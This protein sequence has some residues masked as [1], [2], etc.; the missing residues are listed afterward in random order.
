[1]KLDKNKDL[2]QLIELEQTTPITIRE[3]CYHDGCPTDWT[4]RAITPRDIARQSIPYYCNECAHSTN[5]QLKQGER[6]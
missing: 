5:Y 3:Y 4:R 6:K 1:M 2:A